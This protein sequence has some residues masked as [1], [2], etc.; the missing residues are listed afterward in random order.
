MDFWSVEIGIIIGIA[1]YEWLVLPRI[2]KRSAARY[3][4][5]MQGEIRSIEKVK[6]RERGY[7]G[8][9]YYVEYQINE[10]SF[11]S[12]ARCNIFGQIVDWS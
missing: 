4:R 8:P 7:N 12:Y 2:M 5:R 1:L 9:W 3:I 6:K 10:Y 11:T